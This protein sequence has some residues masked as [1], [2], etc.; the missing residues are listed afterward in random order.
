[1]PVDVGAHTDLPYEKT[2]VLGDSGETK[3]PTKLPTIFP[4]WI[5]APFDTQNLF[6]PQSGRERRRAVGVTII[7]MRPEEVPGSQFQ[8]GE[9]EHG[10]G[11]RHVEKGS[12]HSIDANHV[13]DGSE[14]DGDTNRHKDG[15]IDHILLVRA[16]KEQPR[17]RDRNRI[18]VKCT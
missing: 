1:M 11:L 18:N 14:H 4:L 13:R 6:H 8:S 7:T 2:P 10:D 17:L 15:A 16:G 3:T 5:A 9:V 12:E